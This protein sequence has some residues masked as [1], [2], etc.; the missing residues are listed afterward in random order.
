M[1]FKLILLL[2]VF[3]SGCSTLAIPETVTMELGTS[4]RHDAGEVPTQI[5]SAIIKGTW[6]F[7]K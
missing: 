6:R 5:N 7:K 3:L 4:V 1:L 2:T